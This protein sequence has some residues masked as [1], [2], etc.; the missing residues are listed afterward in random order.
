MNCININDTEKYMTEEPS[1]IGDFSEIILT[2]IKV[3]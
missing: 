1:K 2:T 3:I